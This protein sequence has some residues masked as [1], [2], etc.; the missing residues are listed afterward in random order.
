MDEEE[1]GVGAGEDA[2][3]DVGGGGDWAGGGSVAVGEG[4]LEGESAPGR[5][6]LRSIMA[7]EDRLWI[8]A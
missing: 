6:W 3:G 8:W 5:P 1:A 7:P 4:L 2:R